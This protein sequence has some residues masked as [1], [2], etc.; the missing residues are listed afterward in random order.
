MTTTE[1]KRPALRRAITGPLLY[2]FILGD[3]LGA[4]V[5]ALIGVIAVEVG[6]A[7]WAPML[8]ALGMA[9]LTA[10]SYAELVTKYP[11]AGGA[12]VFAERAFKRPIVS[13]LVGFSMLAAGLTSAAALALAFGG[14]YLGTFIDV[15][16]PLAAVVFLALVALV[17]ARGIR[18]SMG[19]NTVMTIIETSGLVIVIVLVAILL[20]G[21]GGEPARVLEFKPDVDP[22]VATFGAAIIAFYS[23]V[24]F[25]VSANV[26]EE[27]KNP[28]KIYPRALFAALST[29]AFVYL[30]IGIASTITLP[31]AQL[32]ESSAPLLDVVRATG[33]GLPPQVF[34][35]IALVAVANGALLAMIMSSRLTY[36]MADSGLLPGVFTRVLAGRRTPWVAI[37]TTTAVAMLLTLS[38]GVEVLAETVVLLLLFV[39]LSV[40][41]AVLVLRKDPVE[42]EHFR[43]PKALPYL[44]IVSCLVLL[45]QQSGEVW[46]RGLILIAVGVALYGIAALARSRRTPRG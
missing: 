8:L 18:E 12:A 38:G 27:M 10:S 3:V 26:A 29:A 13:F 41:V 28:A 19:A 11:K 46:L 42:H 43:T 23:F 44:A 14:D 40:N 7:V 32:G 22:L 39:F 33:V 35:A 45:S 2:F 21:G 34:S 24:G 30:L 31:P 1:E 16:A 37:V 4:G 25:E 15:P 20:G 9:L 6:G 5:Y 36:G 17:N